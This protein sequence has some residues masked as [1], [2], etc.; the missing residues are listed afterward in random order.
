MLMPAYINI[1]TNT[2]VCLLL[3]LLNSSTQRNNPINIL[4]LLRI[5]VCNCAEPNT[6]VSGETELKKLAQ[7]QMT[8]NKNLA[9][10]FSARPAQ[11]SSLFYCVSS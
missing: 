11:C 10:I 2:H 6:A 1:N 3:D 4:L 8:L 9:Q 5:G 7:Y